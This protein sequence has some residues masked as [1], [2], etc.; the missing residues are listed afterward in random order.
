MNAD[1]IVG[2]PLVSAEMLAEALAGR[3]WIDGGFWAE[4]GE[5]RTTVMHDETGR[6]LGIVSFAVREKD[7]VGVILWL[8][9][10]GQELSTIEAL[11]WHALAEL[12]RRTVV[13]FDFA[14]ALTVGL[15]ALPVRHRATTRQALEQAGF[16]GADLWR[17]IHRSLRTPWATSGPPKA[18]I[19]DGDEDGTW[20]SYCVDQMDR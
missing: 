10:S 3:S 13:A 9:A 7:D 11:V 6:L 18:D 14:S 12:G 5:I 19:F 8:Y 20:S 17:Y 16:V 4:L 1:R 2:Q 15:E